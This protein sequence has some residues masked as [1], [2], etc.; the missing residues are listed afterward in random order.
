MTF[1]AL[2][3]ALNRHPG[4]IKDIQK[5]FG[6]PVFKGAAYSDSYAAF[7]RRLAWLSHAILLQFNKVNV[8]K[9]LN[10]HLE[11]VFDRDIAL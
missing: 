8:K 7:L 10:T 6:L 1:S 11:T 5:R 9:S 3:T 4:V 2:C